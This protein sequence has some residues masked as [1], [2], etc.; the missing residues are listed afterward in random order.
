MNTL[1]N[2][3]QCHI[4][5]ND[6]R[7]PLTSYDLPDLGVNSVGHMTTLQG[8]RKFA[9][10]GKQGET[11]VTNV[12]NMLQPVVPAPHR[13]TLSLSWMQYEKSKVGVSL[14]DF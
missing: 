3:T 9:G 10:L 7:H 2:L 14:S 4:L 12:L 6:L 11:F 5:G 13:A 8:T 1:T